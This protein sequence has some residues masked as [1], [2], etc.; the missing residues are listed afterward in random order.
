[1][2]DRHKVKGKCE[3][4]GEWVV[5]YLEPLFTQTFFATQEEKDNAEKYCHIK[6][7]P[8]QSKLV[9][10]NTVGQ[11]T[12]EPDKNG[13][14]IF[15]H[16]IIKDWRGVAGVVEYKQG[17]FGVNFTDGAK[18][19]LCFVNEKCEIIGNIYD[20]PELLGGDGE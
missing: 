18:Q 10:K 19:F 15:E 6:I 13:K 4:S 11:C 16:D 2:L 14:L 12:G 1:M 9:L 17:A 20:N 8:F 5:G 3:D 7:N